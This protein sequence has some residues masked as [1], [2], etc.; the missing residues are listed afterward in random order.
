LTSLTATPH[1]LVVG[2]SRGIGRTVARRLAADGDRVSIIGRSK[3]SGDDTPG[4][5]SW[6]ADVCDADG[7]ARVLDDVARSGSVSGLVLLQRYR[8]SGDEWAGEIATTLT[9]TRQLLDWAGSH[10]EDRGRGKSVVVVSSIAGAFVASEQPVSYHM[11]KAAL[12]QMVRYYAVALGP[13]GIRVNA[14]SPGTIVKD[15]SR[16]FYASQPDLE[17]LYRDIVPLG[18]MGTAD[19]LA[20]LA[21]FLLS[22]QASFLTGQ[23]I[24]LD[25]GVSLRSHESLA[26]SVSPLKDLQVSR[27]AD[28]KT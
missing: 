10:L 25:G 12:T 15:E 16:A 27:R 9:A 28:T 3:P 23:N 19:D 7:L 4:I 26:R 13:R 14:I 8:G 20:G 18:R 6:T 21:Q 5:Q 11:A 1:T 22:D 24:V 2:G 17:Q